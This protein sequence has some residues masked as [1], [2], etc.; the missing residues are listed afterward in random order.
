[1]ENEFRYFNILIFED[2]GMKTERLKPEKLP[3]AEELEKTEVTAKFFRGLGDPTRLKILQ[4]LLEKERNVSELIGLLGVS[5]SKASNHLACLKWCG[6]VSARQE[7]KHVYYQ[8]T[9]KRVKHILSLAGEMIA[10]NA[11][12]LWFCTRI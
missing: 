12:H 11:K 8:I 6:Y 1:M 7:G 10:D 3:T 4:Y 5:Q 9:D 2:F